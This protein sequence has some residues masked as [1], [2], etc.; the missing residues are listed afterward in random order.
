[1]RPVVRSTAMRRFVSG[2]VMAFVVAG[3][4]GV[5]GQ[6]LAADKFQCSIMKGGKKTTQSVTTREECTKLHGK[7]IEANSPFKSKSSEKK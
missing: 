1:M 2:L 5:A 6:S 3:F 7:V 4:L